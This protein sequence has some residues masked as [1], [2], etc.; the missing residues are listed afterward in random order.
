M[1]KHYNRCSTCGEPLLAAYCRQHQPR[2][3]LPSFIQW[4]W[5]RLK[6]FFTGYRSFDPDSTE[7]DEY[8]RELEDEERLAQRSASKPGKQK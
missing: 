3:I 6:F 1:G 7:L 5:L 4:R 8:L 2:H